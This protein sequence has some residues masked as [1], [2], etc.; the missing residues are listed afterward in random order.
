[1]L[2]RKG[3]GEE[4]GKY[5]YVLVIMVLNLEKMFMVSLDSKLFEG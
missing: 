1:M 4:G 3:R 2:V 5:D